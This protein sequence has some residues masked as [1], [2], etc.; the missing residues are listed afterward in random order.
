MRHCLLVLRYLMMLPS[1]LLYCGIALA[2][3]RRALGS[4]SHA[5]ERRQRSRMTCPV[6]PSHV[7]A[8]FPVMPRLAEL[9]YNYGYHKQV[10]ARAAGTAG[11]CRS[12]AHMLLPELRHCLQRLP[13]ASTEIWHTRD[14]TGPYRSGR[15]PV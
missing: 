7:I 8:L 5:V 2:L 4:K 10:G 3:R 15:T 12:L 9:S 6:P 1:A 11:R 13:P 14:P